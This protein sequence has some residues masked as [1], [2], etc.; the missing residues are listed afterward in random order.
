MIMVKNLYT[1][2]FSVCTGEMF[3]RPM[4]FA[5]FFLLSLWKKLNF[6]CSCFNF[7]LYR[8]QRVKP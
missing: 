6:V 4:W 7:F 3:T 8:L 2:F 1:F 5:L